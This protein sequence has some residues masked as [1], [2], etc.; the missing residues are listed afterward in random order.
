MKVDVVRG[1]IA[2]AIS[3]LLA[4]AC[5]EICNFERVQWVV[6][7]GAVVTL[8]IP[9][10]FALGVSSK[11]ERSSVVLKTLSWLVFT[12][13]LLSNGIFVFFDFSVPV[14]VILNGLILVFFALMYNSIFRT[15]M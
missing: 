2:F 15:K 10:M 4:Y 14:Y 11:Q 13:G 1:F 12:V 3:A 8:G 5:Y 9:L 6:T 7:I